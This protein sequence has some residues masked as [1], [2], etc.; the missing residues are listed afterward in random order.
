MPI[1]HLFIPDTQ[2]KPGVPIDHL[3]WIGK[4]IVEKKPD[5]VIHAGDHAD[6]PSL[7]SYDRGKKAMEGR[8]Y[9]A[10]VKAAR[11]GWDVLNGPIEKHNKK[12]KKN[13]EKQYKPRK[14]I[15]L[16]NHEHRITREVESDARLEGIVSVD[17]LGLERYGWE[18]IPFLELVEIDGVFYSHYFANPMTGKPYGGMIQTRLKTIGFSFTQGHVQMKD[19][20]ELFRANGDVVRGCVAGAC[21]LHDEH[22][23]G[24]QGNNHWRGII[25]KHQVQNGNYDL[26]EVSLDFLCR[27]YEGVSLADYEPKVFA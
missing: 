27:H 16:G 4:Y 26:M 3:A 9:Q 13:K 1:E 8:R 14:V 19:T 23:K 17:N 7:S 5:V 12:K 24:P 20:G 6:M 10:D 18:V 21:Y 2:V 22:Y 15:T 11:R 25:Y